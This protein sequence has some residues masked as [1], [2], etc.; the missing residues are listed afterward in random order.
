M[1]ILHISDGGPTDQILQVVGG[2][3]PVQV[4]MQLDQILCGTTRS[5][6]G[7]KRTVSQKN[8]CQSCRRLVYKS[9]LELNTYAQMVN[10][11]VPGNVANY[12]TVKIYHQ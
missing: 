7:W 9:H 10:S 8:S 2:A 12:Y 5:F 4:C 11:Q 3:N 6:R 1:L